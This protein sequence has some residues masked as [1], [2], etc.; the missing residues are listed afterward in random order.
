M[1][2]EY[3]LTL[4][5]S[6]PVEQLATR[7]VPEEHPTGTPELLSAD[8]YDRYGFE[9]TIL[10]GENGYVSASSDTGM[11]EWEPTAFTSIGFRM[12]K[13]ADFTWEVTN[14]LTVVRRV[15]QTGEENAVLVLNSDV[16]LFTRF[17]GELVK[18]RREPWWDHYAGANEI[19]PG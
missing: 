16:L 5:G 7:A 12:D 18:H 17:G 19:L 13:F 14:M 1:A 2:L 8:L 3:E 9:L 11:W 10:A 6:I 15:L 4:E